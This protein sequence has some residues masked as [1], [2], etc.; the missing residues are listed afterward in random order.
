MTTVHKCAYA[1]AFI[2]L[3]ALVSCR[4][5]EE[6]A[7]EPAPDTQPKE[8]GS[9]DVLSLQDPDDLYGKVSYILGYQNSVACQGQYLGI[10]PYYMAKGAIDAIE[11]DFIYTDDEMTEILSEY[12][13]L[14]QERSMA[15]FLDTKEKNLKAA[16]EFLEANG[17]RN[18]V[19]SLS[20]KLQYEVLSPAKEGARKAEED[21]NVTLNYQ[22]I[23]LDGNLLD[24]SYEKDG[25]VSFNLSGVIDGF[26]MVMC[27]MA[28]GEKVRAWIHSDLGYGDGTYTIEPG[29]LLIFDIELI[30]V[31]D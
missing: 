13:K 27:E 20:D 9:I 18:G 2:L 26:R 22:L 25:G 29:L 1:L 7:K 15:A 24:S 19:I 17:Q 8:D 12:Q 16:V 30:K 14:L 5:N 21:S 23:D 4:A 10:D 6:P 28:E 11:G 31:E 3:L